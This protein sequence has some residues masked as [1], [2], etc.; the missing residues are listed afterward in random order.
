MTRHASTHPRTTTT[1]GYAVYFRS[2]GKQF[3]FKRSYYFEINPIA[4]VDLPLLTCRCW[5]SLVHPTR[6]RSQMTTFIIVYE[7]FTYTHH[8][9]VDRTGI[10]GKTQKKIKFPKSKKNRSMIDASVC[11]CVYACM[12]RIRLTRFFR[13]QTGTSTA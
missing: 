11:V 13:L 9:H 2:A 4:A 10:N 7:I 1:G 12:F 6:K 5:M 8:T 3:R